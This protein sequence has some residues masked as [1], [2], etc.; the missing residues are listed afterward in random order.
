MSVRKRKNHRENES[1]NRE[2]SREF[3]FQLRLENAMVN[4]AFKLEK[5]RAKRRERYVV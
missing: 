1:L 3:L 5:Q 2:I 4:E